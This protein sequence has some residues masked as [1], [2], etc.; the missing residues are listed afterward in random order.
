[1]STN[2]IHVVRT[3]RKGSGATSWYWDEQEARSQF[4]H[5]KESAGTKVE[6]FRIEAEDIINYY[7][8]YILDDE[9]E[10]HYELLDSFDSETDVTWTDLDYRPE[11]Y[12]YIERTK[13]STAEYWPFNVVPFAQPDDS[14]QTWR[15]MDGT[16]D[17][18]MGLIRHEEETF[19]VTVNGYRQDKK[20][21]GLKAAVQFVVSEFNG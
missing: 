11:G 18:P 5:L 13:A 9:S 14:F 1:M 12:F 15:V 3:T 7:L 16:T 17:T 4:N 19:S 21:V 20:F 2:T 8:D 10:V 6:L